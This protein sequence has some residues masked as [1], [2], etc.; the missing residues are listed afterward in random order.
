MDDPLLARA[1]LAIEESQALR[2]TRRA[3]QAQQLHCREALR[4]SVMESAMYLTE[5]KA[6][7]E[8]RE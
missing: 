5:C 3:L 2:T 6:F 1:Q 7:R 4:L 8:D